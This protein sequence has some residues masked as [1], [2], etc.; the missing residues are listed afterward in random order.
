MTE[1]ITLD[2]VPLII[3][4]R[5]KYNVGAYGGD[6]LIE[7]TLPDATTATVGTV[8]AG[9]EMTLSLSGD[10]ADIVLTPQT[11]GMYWDFDEIYS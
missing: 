8:S 4:G 1:A 11:L 6:L 2:P 7:R 10:R 3:D 9:T 5:R